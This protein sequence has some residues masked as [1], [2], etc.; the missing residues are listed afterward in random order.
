MGLAT[1]D[2][3]VIVVGAGISGVACGREL[4]AA[5]VPV[6]VLDRAPALGGRMALLRIDGRVVDIGASYLTAAEPEFLELVTNWRDRGLVRP[7]TDTFLT[8]EP[9]GLT[10]AT[11]GP[12]R[13]ATRGGLRS[14]VEDLASGL[15]VERPLEVEEVSVTA[16]VLLVD[17][18]PAAAVALAMPDPQALDLLPSTAFAKNAASGRDWEAVLSVAM[19]WESHCWPEL[20][21]VFV[22]DSPVLAWVADDGRRRGDGA[23]VLVA[24]STAG[25]AAAHLDEPESGVEAMVAAVASVL[26]IEHPPRWTSAHRWGLARPVEGRDDPYFLGDSGIGLC[27][28]GWHGRPRVEGAWLS[29]RDLGRALVQRLV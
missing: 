2:R 4:V 24:H 9:D 22:N 16:R 18:M 12:L 14:L 3:P 6:R 15:A 21:G 27:G 17:G 20:D 7:W 26:G 28:D 25:F 10:G 5:G 23:A 11:S 1:A 29:G 13:W 19:G 8:A